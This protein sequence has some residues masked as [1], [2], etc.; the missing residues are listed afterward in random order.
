MTKYHFPLVPCKCSMHPEDHHHLD[1]YT[2]I[3]WPLFLASMKEYFRK[4]EAEGSGHHGHN[5]GV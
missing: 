3:P 4:K 2:V 1:S 5:D